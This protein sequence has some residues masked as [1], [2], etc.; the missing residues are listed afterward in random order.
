MKKAPDQKNPIRGVTEQRQFNAKSTAS[1]AQRQR[2]I[3]ALRISPKNS[4]E[5]RELGVYQQ[6]TRILELRRKGFEITTDRVTLWDAFG[7]AHRNCALYTL[8]SVPEVQR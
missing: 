3:N 7:Y 4:H 1:E 6:S 8:V 5:L 2:I